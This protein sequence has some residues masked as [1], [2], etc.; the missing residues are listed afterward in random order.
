MTHAMIMTFTKDLLDAYAFIVVDDHIPIE[1]VR[2]HASSIR[3]LEP[4]LGSHHSYHL[5]HGHN[6]SSHQDS[7]TA[8]SISIKGEVY[9]TK[10]P[11][12]TIILVL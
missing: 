11:T 10:S 8:Y 3:Y 4:H 6:D 9:D 12:S 5:D 7:L 1:Y 2:I